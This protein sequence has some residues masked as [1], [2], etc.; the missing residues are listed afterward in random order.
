M[1]ND[2]PGR[3]AFY[4]VFFFFLTPLRWCDELLKYTVVGRKVC[5]LDMGSF[6]T[7]TKFGVLSF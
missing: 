2:L 6:G 7:V 5:G 3:I 1:G 4:S